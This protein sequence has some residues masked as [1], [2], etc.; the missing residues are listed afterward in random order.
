MNIRIKEVKVIKNP[1][2]EMIKIMMQE[3]DN[4][5]DEKIHQLKKQKLNERYL[6][7]DEFKIPEKP[8][9]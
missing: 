3:K 8:V 2:R 6:E 5:K 4:E 7:D 9:E 1:F